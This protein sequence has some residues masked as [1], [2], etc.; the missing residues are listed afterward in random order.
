MTVG[1]VYWGQ[2][3]KFLFMEVN[4]NDKS[5]KELSADREKAI[6]KTSV[7]GI[8]TNVFLAAF[9]AVIGII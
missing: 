6:V 3:Y 4:M 7:I 5:M 8:V 1:M 2:N 9:K